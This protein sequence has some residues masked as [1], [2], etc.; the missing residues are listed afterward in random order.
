[1]MRSTDQRKHLGLSGVCK[2]LQFCLIEDLLLM[3]GACTGR[4]YGPTFAWSPLHFVQDPLDLVSDSLEIAND[5]LQKFGGSM[6]SQLAQL[7]EAFLRCLQEPRASARKKATHC[8]GMP[9]CL[10]LLG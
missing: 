10:C 8:L 2:P 6:E 5:L 4:L 9:L 7:T 3:T 1:M